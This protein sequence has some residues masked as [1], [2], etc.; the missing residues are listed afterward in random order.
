MVELTAE[1]LNFS[2]ASD[3][4]LVVRDWTTRFPRGSVSA[5]TGSSG[6]GKS[7]RLYLMAL[8]LRPQSGAIRLSGERVDDLPDAK[9][10]RI[11]AQEFGF[12][13]QD[14]A[15]DSSRSVLDNVLETSIYRGLDPRVSRRRALEMLDA[16]EVDVPLRRLPGQ[17]SGGQAQ[18]IALCRALLGSPSVIFADE[19]T[20]NLDASTA[21]AVLATLRAAADA[22]STVVVVTH[23]QLVAEWADF[24]HEASVF[25]AD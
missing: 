17:I 20:G 13:F 10:S 5:I 4:R 1:G 6:S 9:R 19:P 15:L 22:G 25:K 18:R 12:V 2:Y 7:T 11:R 23:D 8:M 24:R 16:L 21:K 3:S 14:A